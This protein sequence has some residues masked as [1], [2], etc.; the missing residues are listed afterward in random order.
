MILIR[1]ALEEVPELLQRTV[2]M[3]NE[4]LRLYPI[5]VSKVFT[6]EV[7]INKELADSDLSIICCQETPDSPITMGALGFIAGIVN[8][9]KYRIY[10]EMPD[11]DPTTI[12]AFGVY[13]V[14]EQA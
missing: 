5:A 12:I 11:D 4:C 14:E 1:A 13:R 6:H 7:P 10:R 2:R 3:L 8:T 9:E